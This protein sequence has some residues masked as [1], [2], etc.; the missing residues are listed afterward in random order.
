MFANIQQYYTSS[1][2]QLSNSAVVSYLMHGFYYLVLSCLCAFVSIELY[3]IVDSMMSLPED[4]IVKRI[5]LV[6]GVLLGFVFAYKY[7]SAY[8]GALPI[9][10]RYLTVAMLTYIAWAIIKE[11]IYTKV[12]EYFLHIGLLV[13]FFIT[14]RFSKVVSGANLLFVALATSIMLFAYHFGPSYSAEFAKS[15]VF[16][17]DII[18]NLAVGL[19][20]FIVFLISRKRISLS[21]KKSRQKDRMQIEALTRSTSLDQILSEVA[22]EISQP[23][24]SI[25]IDSEMASDILKSSKCSSEVDEIVDDVVVKTDHCIDVIANIKNFVSKEEIKKEQVEVNKSISKMF[26]LLSHELKQYNIATEQ[27]L[28]ESKSTVYMSLIELEQV[29]LN[30]CKNAISAM[31]SNTRSKNKLTIV[32][33]S[34]GNQV[35][36]IVED[37]GCEVQNKEELFSLFK[38]TKQHSY[39]EG[40]GL[41]LSLSRKIIR[42]YEGTLKLLSSSEKG[43]KFIIE[44][45]KYAEE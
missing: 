34:S 23:I 24:T 11:D 20:F 37:T 33:Q 16:G 19:G 6:S 36:I 12:P 4:F 9:L 27:N 2:Y 14:Y 3:Y 1:I 7:S 41:G 22:H 45:P 10:V 25:K 13:G 8:R 35:Q 32:S 29:L 18:S 42:S 30:L 43:T 28:D 31:A 17:K 40:L 44:L 21:Y 38:S 5:S 26:K 15:D 39:D